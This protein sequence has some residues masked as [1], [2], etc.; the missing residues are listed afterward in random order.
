MIF[1]INKGDLKNVW[2]A[3]LLSQFENLK[4]NGGIKRKKNVLTENQTEGVL[5]FSKL[6]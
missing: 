5:K 2:V 1:Y 3:K 4:T 6:N